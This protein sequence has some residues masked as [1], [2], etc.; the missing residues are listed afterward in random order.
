[1][2][3][4]EPVDSVTR[5]QVHAARDAIWRAWFAADTESLARLLP[6][7]VAAG[8]RNGWESRDST[9]AAARQFAAQ[10]GRL[11]DIRFDSTSIR[12]RGSVAVV[13]SRYHL[14]LDQR[15]KRVTRTGVATEIF[16]RENGRWVNP[17]W[18]L[19]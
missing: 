12:L 16:V 15:G 2:L 11:V 7:A 19:E 1:M 3:H 4:L 6:S 9:I 8:S 17:F 10:Q 13:Q 5:A 18:Y 14:V